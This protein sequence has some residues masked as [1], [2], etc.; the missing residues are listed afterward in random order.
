[1][2]P[3]IIIGAGLAGWTTVRE[4]RKLDTTTPVVVITRDSGDFYAKP[5][6]SNAFAQKRTPEQLV[7]TPAAKMAD[8]LQVTLLAHT[9]VEAIDLASHT[10]HTT[11]GDTVQTLAYSRLVLA[12]GAQPIRVPVQGNAAARVQSVNALDD[13]F[14]FFYGLS[15]RGTCADSYQI[16]SKNIVIMGAGL[17]GCEF[18]NDLA[19]AGHRVQVVDPSTRPLAALLPEPAGLQLQEALGA[20]GVV[21]HFGATV[22]AVDTSNPTHPALTVQLSNGQTL[23]ADAVLSAIG[24]RADTSLASAAGL[25]CERGIMVD[26]YLHTSDPLVF[27]LGDG[28]Q[29]ASAGHRTLP[30]VMPIMHAAKALAATLG[31]T[32]TPVVFPLMP[33]AIKTPA[34]PIVVAAAHPAQ[35]GAWSAA[36]EES[37][38]LWRFLDPQG[39]QRGFVLSGKHTTRRM[40]QAKATSL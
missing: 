1:M 15:P 10:V 26:A 27:A 19:Q 2:A 30:Y 29:Y 20:Q 18:A 34:L 11:Q 7:N 25:N 23:A 4:F 9:Q 17:I 3:L 24:L 36:D 35:A 6:L 28:A 31:G 13:F 38:G 21:W 37:V 40:E 22:Q 32:P 39:V 8:T 12:T 16:E 33:V 14:S 5:S